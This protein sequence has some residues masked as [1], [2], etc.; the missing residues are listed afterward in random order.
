[1]AGWPDHRRRHLL[2]RD[3][4]SGR[5]REEEEMGGIRGSVPASLAPYCVPRAPV[6]VAPLMSYVARPHPA[7]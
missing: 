5:M 4:E 2:E 6:R 3:E 1:V 7:G